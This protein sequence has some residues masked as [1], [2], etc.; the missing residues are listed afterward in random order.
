MKVRTLLI[1]TAIIGIVFGCCFLVL[2]GMVLPLYGISADPDSIL[3]LR[4]FGGGLIG[5]L[6]LA[7]AAR[8]AGPSDARQAILLS[9]LIT[10]IIG[11]VLTLVGIFSG[12]LSGIAWIGIP[13]FLLLSLGFAY[14]RFLK[15]D[16]A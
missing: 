2:P 5:Y 16:A 1:I 6:V 14:F 8:G 4:F 3:I 10:F 9:F 12:V 7:W 15:P 13:V 11:L